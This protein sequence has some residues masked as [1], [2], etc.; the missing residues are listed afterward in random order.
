M[1]AAEEVKLLLPLLP[2]LLCAAATP[3]PTESFSDDFERGLCIGRCAGWNWPWWQEVDGTLDVVSNRGG[4]ALRA[5]TQARGKRVPKAA[6]VARP[7]KL[8]PGDTAEIGFDLLVPAGAPLNSIHLVDV[9]CASCGEEGNPGI[10]LYLR[11][12]RLRIDRSKIRHADAWLDDRA[13]Q[14]RHARWHRIELRVAV[15][16]GDAGSA[17][18]RL[19]G[20]AVL[21]GSGDTVARPSG[22]AAAGADRIQIGLTA[23]SNAGPATVYIDNIRVAIARRS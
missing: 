20:R 4:R 18:V 22:G 3:R 13:P 8:R 1:G 7:P 21:K 16:F 2:L 23:S 5:R 15:G 17:L 12:G 11:H 9:E 19:D 10:R 14:L 6:L